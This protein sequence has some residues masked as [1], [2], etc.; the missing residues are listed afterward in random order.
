MIQASQVDYKNLSKQPFEE[1]RSI[2]M[3]FLTS[4][5]GKPTLETS[6]TS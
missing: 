5:V 3:K 6:I 4:I 1:E 2:H